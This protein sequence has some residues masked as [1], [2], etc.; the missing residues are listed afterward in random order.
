[1]GFSKDFAVG[2]GEA[3]NQAVG[4]SR[5]DINGIYLPD[6]DTVIRRGKRQ[7]DQRPQQPPKPPGGMDPQEGM[8]RAKSIFN[9][10]RGEA[11][12]GAENMSNGGSSQPQ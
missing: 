9:K 1:M 4:R 8:N 12:K 7:S 11:Q 5:R 2:G 10:G 3:F 6:Y